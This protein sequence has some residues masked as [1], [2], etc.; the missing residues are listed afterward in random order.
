MCG[1]VRPDT[2]KELVEVV[3]QERIQ[4]LDHVRRE[5]AAGAEPWRRS[6]VKRTARDVQPA[7][8]SQGEL[9]AGV[10][11]VAADPEAAVDQRYARRGF[12]VPGGVVAPER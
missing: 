10:D 6:G 7:V 4:Q 1:A 8:V 2:A 12:R 9:A 5:V 11:P 3:T